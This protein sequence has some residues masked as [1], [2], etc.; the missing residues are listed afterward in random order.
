M[1]GARVADSPRT[2]STPPKDAAKRSGVMGEQVS[3][4]LVR[5]ALV[6]LMLIGAECIHGVLRMM[7]LAP[8]VGDFRARQICAF[9]GSAIVLVIAYLFVG[10]IGA[11]TK[12][13][14]I[15]TGVL[16]LG[17]TVLFEIGLGRFVLGSSWDR[18]LE[19]YD[20]SRGGLLLPALVFLAA[21]PLIAT[22]LRIRKE[23]TTK[24]FAACHPVRANISERSRNLFGDEL[25]T[26]SIGSFT[27]AI[28]IRRAP[29]DV[30]PWLAQMG[31][32]RA[33]W[34]SYDIIDNGGQHSA[35]RMVPEL[36][37]IEVGTTMP[38]LPGVA[39]GFTV[40][41]VEPEQC[42]VLGWLPPSGGPP[43]MTWSFV[44]EEQ[45]PGSTRLIVRARAGVDYHPPFGLPHW[46]LGTFARWAP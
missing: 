10:W 28:T 6:W 18:L 23:S 13:V 15:G 7:F 29:R 36:Q 4:C 33:G 16:W 12:G 21:S 38:T 26:S 31:A 17:L 2:E 5:A 46:T 20:L 1:P 3:A 34:Y 30:W 22:R 39:D 41:R 42:L 24:D 35:A 40:L 14:I 8:Y 27:H 9:T 32:G 45:E 43:L 11:K 44:L 25:L 37:H 19:D